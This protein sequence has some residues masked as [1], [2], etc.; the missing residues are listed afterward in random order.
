MPIGADDLLQDVVGLGG[1]DEGLWMVVVQG[2]VLLNSC[3]QFGNAAKD[4]TLKTIGRDAAKE[5]LDHVQPGR[6]GRC[7]VH[8][9]T[10]ILLQPCPHL[11]MLVRGVIIADQMQVL[12]LWRFAVNLAQEPQPLDVAV[13]VLGLSDDLAIEH[14]ERGKQRGGAVAFVVVGRRLYDPGRVDTG[15]ASAARQIAGNCGDAALRKALAPL[16]CLIATDSSII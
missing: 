16:N 6:R 7:E 1:P 2:D 9:K 15:L 14:V 3:G 12:V 10:R 8:V 5:A 4:A 11:R 13:V